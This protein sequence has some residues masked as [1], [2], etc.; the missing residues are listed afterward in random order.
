MRTRGGVAA[1]LAAAA[2][3]GCAHTSSGPP[4][5]TISTASPTP[6]ATPSAGTALAALARAGAAASYTATYRLLPSSSGAPAELRVAHTPTAL[7]LD[8]ITAGAD[9]VLI[10]N[11]HGDYSCRL[12]AGA[13]VCLEV[14]GPR[15]ALPATFDPGL[16]GVFGSYLAALGGG[17]PSGVTAAGTTPASARVPAGRC[18]AVPAGGTPAAGTYC[19]SAAGIPVQ[20][21]FAA[22]GSLHATAVGPAPSNATLHP[23]VSPTPLPPSP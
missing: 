20:V 10:E 13:P 18:F 4:L 23:P 9:A 19:L 17:Q 22:G 6:S 14:A 11:V 16:E 7:R 1:A 5:P 8:V 12:G 21:T 3:A 15:G 2:L